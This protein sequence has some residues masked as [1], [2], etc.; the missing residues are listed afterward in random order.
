VIIGLG[1]GWLVGEGGGE[2]CDEV[3]YELGVD[4]Y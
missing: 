2:G 4:C 1:V 3:G